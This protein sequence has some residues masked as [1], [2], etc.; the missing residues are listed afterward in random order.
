MSKKGEQL[1][2]SLIEK[3]R[4]QAS[5]Y[6]PSKSLAIRETISKTTKKTKARTKIRKLSAKKKVKPKKKPK[7][8]AINKSKKK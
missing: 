7:K 2:K 4:S 5:E 3:M 6:K 1:I 8:K